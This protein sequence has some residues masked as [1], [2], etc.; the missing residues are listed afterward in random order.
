MYLNLILNQ[1]I[2]KEQTVKPIKNK[3]KKSKKRKD[4]KIKKQI[5]RIIQLSQTTPKVETIKEESIIEP[6]EEVQW[7]DETDLNI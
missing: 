1:E 7:R 2:R 5:S 4:K 6:K 3:G